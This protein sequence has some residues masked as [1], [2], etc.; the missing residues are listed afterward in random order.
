VRVA[1]YGGAFDPPTYGHKYVVQYLLDTGLAE[2]VYIIPCADHT[3]KKNLTNSNIRYQ[4]CKAMFNDIPGG[5]LCDI[6]IKEKLP[7]D[8]Y[9]LMKRLQIYRPTDHLFFVVGSDNV[10][11]MKDWINAEK[12]IS[13]YPYTTIPRRAEYKSSSIIRAEIAQ[14]VFDGFGTSNLVY[15]IIVANSLYGCSTTVWNGK[16]L[17][18]M[19]RNNWEFVHRKQMTV[20]V[21]A[22]DLSGRMLFVLQRREP[23]DCDTVELPSGLVDP[24]EEPWQAAYRE[25]L[26]E[27]GYQ[28]PEPNKDCL[29]KIGMTFC[30]SPGLTD[31]KVQ[32]YIAHN[33]TKVAEP[34]KGISVLGTFNPLADLKA[35]VKSGCS[36]GSSAWLLANLYQRD[37]SLGEVIC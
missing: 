17:Q 16:H 25:L 9:T 36:I 11:D 29:P 28:A 22:L 31:E 24:G 35:L 37:K 20:S 3:F 4:M 6:A 13:N 14:G 30:K 19:C 26:E 32:F 27:T 10:K 2:K 18:M 23:M 21:A 15:D 1:I 34:E 5:E 33:C 7:S 12:L 8:T